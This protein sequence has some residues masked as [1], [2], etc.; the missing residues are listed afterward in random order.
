[1]SVEQKKNL[2]THMKDQRSQSYKLHNQAGE[3]IAQ[4]YFLNFDFSSDKIIGGYWPIGSELDL[5]PLL[6]QLY[7]RG[8]KC[9]LPCLE[10]EGMIYRIWTPSTPLLQ[11]KFHTLEPPSISEEVSPDII[12]VPLL[13]FDRKGHRLGYGKGHFDRYLEKHKAFTI[14]VAFQEQ[15]VLEVPNQEHDQALNSVLTN[16]E[17]ISVLPS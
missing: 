14:G 16:K 3:D 6:N 11:K 13:A 7:E 15:E 4:L 1:M 17:V 2:R 9:A 5:R 12:F 8:Y 10:E